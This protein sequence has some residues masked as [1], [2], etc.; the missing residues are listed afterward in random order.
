MKLEKIHIRDFKRFSNLSIDGLPP[1]VKLVL[2]T[3]PNG[4]G[5][6]S[7][8]EAFNY[9]MKLA[10]RQDW[11]YDEDYYARSKKEES[12]AE[13]AARKQR[14]LAQDAWDKITPKFFNIDAD[15]RNNQDACKKVFYIRSAY[16]H[17][18]DFTS[19]GLSRLDDI[20][21]DTSRAHKLILS[22]SRVQD[23]YQRLVGMSLES[24]YDR[25]Q[26]DRTAGQITDELIGEVR[27]AMQKVFDGLV[28]DGPGNPLEGGTFR[29]TKGESSN[30]HYKNLSGGEKAAF[31]LLLDFIVKRKKFD[32]TI[33]CIDEPE[34]HMHTRLQAKLLEVM[35]DLIPDNCQLWLS[36]HSIGMARKA[37]ELHAANP[38]Q[39]AF[40]DFHNQNFDQVATLKPIQPDRKFWQQIFHTALDDLA[41]LVVPEYVVF[42]E[43][44]KIGQM[45][46]KPSFDASVYQ[47]IFDPWCPEVEF[48]PLGGGN[49]VQH[50]GKAFDY[51]LTKLAPGM[52][53]W[54]V[55][56]KD[57]RNEA[58]IEELR[59]EGI[60]VLSR[61]DIESFLWDD[62]VLV[63]LCEHFERPEAIDEIKQEKQRQMQ[64]LSG[65]GKPS[66]D[67]KAIT[68]S[69]YIEI[70]KQ[71]GLTGCGNS[72][73]AFSI[74]HL[75]PLLQPGM[76]V[77]EE[78]AAVVMAPLRRKN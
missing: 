34:L 15:I 63:K 46:R 69:L 40:I 23:N 7:L 11:N 61:R 16:R 48:V 3:G 62:E 50:D 76:A 41:E 13:K 44:R 8:F 5:K 49:E 20:L 35:F 10:A 24:L 43:G 26:R 38:G 77:Y 22:E 75:A 28:L 66:D 33:F 52:R 53:T 2:L 37:A 42:C 17:A 71:L 19:E 56:D 70:K 74:E 78:L 27:Q 60:Y 36:T 9:W 25:N 14:N 30:F 64:T 31:D 4:S 29:F 32:D 45:G 21:N 72:A 65:R 51:L 57:D 18:P 54:K 73:E 47:K 39:V 12:P 58:E 68:D 1:T 55:F 67:V 59:Q 6:T